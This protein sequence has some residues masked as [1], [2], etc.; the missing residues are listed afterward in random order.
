[1]ARKMMP[2]EDYLNHLALREYSPTTIRKRRLTLARIRDEL[3]VT[4]LFDAT[5]PEWAAWYGRLAGRVLP[6]SRAAELSAVRAYMRWALERGL[7][8]VDRSARLPMPRIGRRFPRPISE[9]RLVL[10]IATAPERIKPMLLLAAYAGLRACEI[11]GLRRQDILEDVPEPV[12]IVQHG[13]GNTARETSS[14]SCRY[15]P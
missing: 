14:A 10:V 15:T 13:K 3:G 12:L 2:T 6:N 7:I 1:M 9:D 5:E 4:D 8:P 11:A